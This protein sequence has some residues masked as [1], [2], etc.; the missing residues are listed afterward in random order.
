MMV[1]LISRAPGLKALRSK[2]HEQTSYIE[3]PPK[4]RKYLIKNKELIMNAIQF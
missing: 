4:E 1:D 2:K 3:Y